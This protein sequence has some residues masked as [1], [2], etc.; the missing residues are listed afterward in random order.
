MGRSP[1]G[2]AARTLSVTVKVSQNEK[3]L[4]RGL[5]FKTP[6][7]AARQALDLLIAQRLGDEQVGASGGQVAVDPDVA[8]LERVVPR[9]P[10]HVTTPCR[11]HRSYEVVKTWTEFGTKWET[12]VC[13]DC[14]YETSDQVHR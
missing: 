5:G 1:L 7:L 6:G 13:G 12:K 9:V 14:G 10:A 2:A 8:A 3:E 4:L 11:I